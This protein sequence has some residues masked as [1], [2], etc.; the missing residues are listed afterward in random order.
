MS[1]Q[2]NLV[3]LITPFRNGSIDIAALR[4]H[5]QKMIDHGVYGIAVAGTTGEAAMLS[6]QEFEILIRTAVEVAE[7][8]V[9]IIAGVGSNATEATLKK[10]AVA[11][12]SGAQ[13]LL[14]VTPYYVKPTPRGLYEHY[15]ACARTAGDLPII[16]Y[17]VPGRTGVNMT[18][19]VVQ[20]LLEFDNITAIKEASGNLEQM[21]KL[22]IEAGDRL[23][24]LCGDDALTLPALSIGAKGVVSVV[25]NIL[26]KEVTGLFDSHMC[27][28]AKRA[29]EIHNHLLPLARALFIE[30]N[31]IPVKTA[32]ALM[33]A[34]ACEFRLPMVPMEAQN[35]EQLKTTLRHYGLI[36]I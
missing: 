31:P 4:Q 34:I 8:K 28:N 27:G 14:I 30:T 12:R 32:L 17:N 19:Q 1:F 16:L 22:I 3:A 33:G 29:L 10:I 7:K 15:K 36:S 23:A 11:K 5:C 9:P 2:G 35:L 6:E 26:P 18:P 20:T 24:V 21:S 25:S 13:G